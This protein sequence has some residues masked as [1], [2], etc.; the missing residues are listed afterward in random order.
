MIATVSY[1]WEILAMTIE[2]GCLLVLGLWSLVLNHTP[3]IARMKSL[4][5][6]WGMGNREETPMV[7]PWVGRAD[8]AQRNHLDNLPMLAIVVLVAHLTG[9]HDS[10]TVAAAIAMVVSRVGHSV[11]YILGITALRPLF[12]LVSILAM[13]VIVQRVVF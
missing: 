8:R 6:E 2:L 10:A 5:L 7:A 12:Y 13:F 1:F 4:G 11:V 3:A 9:T